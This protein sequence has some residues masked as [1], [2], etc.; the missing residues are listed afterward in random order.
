MLNQN[1]NEKKYVTSYSAWFDSV[2]QYHGC[3][4]FEGLS[5]SIRV[6]GKFT[7]EFRERIPKPEINAASTPSYWASLE[8]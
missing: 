8:D 6:D 1:T 5:F 3:D 2:N 4:P 7:D